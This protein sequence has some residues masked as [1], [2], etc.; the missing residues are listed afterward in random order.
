MSDLPEGELYTGRRVR[1]DGGEFRISM[2]D[3]IRG[4]M[5]VLEIKDVRKRKDSDEATA[6]KN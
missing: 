6:L 2:G 5:E 4:R 1:I 3:F